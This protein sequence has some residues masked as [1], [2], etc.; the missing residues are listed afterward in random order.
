MTV[1]VA[2]PDTTNTIN[3]A[4]GTC[5]I[6]VRAGATLT[7]SGSISNSNLNITLASGSSLFVAGGTTSSIGTLTQSGAST[8]DFAAGNATLTVS[9]LVPSSYAMT[10]SN[11]TS[12]SDHFYATGIT[13]TPARGTANIT[14]L[15]QITLGSNAPSQTYWASGTNELLAVAAIYT[16]WDGPNTTSNNT[17][18]GGA[19]TWD[20]TTTNW[21][22][23]GGAPNGIWAGS[24]NVATFGGTSGGAVTVSGT[25]NAGG[26]TFSTSGYALSGGTLSLGAATN[27]LT[28]GTGVSASIGSIISGTNPIS[29]AGTGALTL[30]GANTYSGATSDT[31]SVTVSDELVVW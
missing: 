23:V 19:G 11:W 29:K 5:N 25:Q 21:T 12:G 16:Y 2:T 31:L 15:N 6:T 24:T 26:L 14:P 22:L 4:T 8:V 18:D 17:V 9:S 1:D 3:A 20:A 7:L 28:V 13:G 30:S 10:V 27:P